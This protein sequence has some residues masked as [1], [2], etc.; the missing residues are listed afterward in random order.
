MIFRTAVAGFALVIA[1]GVAGAVMG[2]G[3]GGML[4]AVIGP[5]RISYSVVWRRAD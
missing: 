2:S 4:G 5:H 3:L 1:M